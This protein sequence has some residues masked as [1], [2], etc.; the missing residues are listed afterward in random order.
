MISKRMRTLVE[1]EGWGIGKPDSN[2]YADIG[3]YSPCGEDFSFGADITD[4]ECFKR[5]VYNYVSNFDPDEHAA[6][7]YGAN[8]G[9]PSSMRM[10]LDDADEILAMLE[11]LYDRIKEVN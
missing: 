3:Q 11:R 10:L 6:M 4:N 7:W 9:E 1:N 8:R 2:G 5:S